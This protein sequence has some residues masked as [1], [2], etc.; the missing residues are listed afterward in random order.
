MVVRV[1]ADLRYKL[2]PA[3]KYDVENV[4]GVKIEADDYL[5]VKKE[6]C[7]K[8]SYHSTDQINSLSI[9]LKSIIEFTF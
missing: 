3:G 5:L 8:I 1:L 2:A 7:L 4:G 6:N 9:D